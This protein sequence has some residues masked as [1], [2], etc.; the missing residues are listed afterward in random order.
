VHPS[1]KFLYA[2]NRG[3]HSIA[4]FAIEDGGRLRPLTHVPCG[5]R[6]PRGFS[7]D[8]SGRWMIVAHQDT[9]TI[10]VF[11]IDPATGIPKPTG[12]TEPV[13]TPTGVK[14]LRAP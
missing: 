14:F 4:I 8:A 11:S 9:H 13:R 7:V 6:T 2:S 10:A 1:G 5:G 12:Q 3:H